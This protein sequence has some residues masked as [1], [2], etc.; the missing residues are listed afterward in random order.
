MTTVAWWSG[1]IKSGSTSS[2]IAAGWDLLPTLCELSGTEVPR[3]LDG[4][5]FAPTLL[6][7]NKDQKKEIIFTGSFTSGEE[8]R[9]FA[10][11]NGKGSDKMFVRTQ[12]LPS[13][14]M[15]CPKILVRKIIL[16]QRTLR[17]LRKSNLR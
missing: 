15:I 5:S 16:L 1:K 12:I 7:R 8:S 2:H 14:S 4:V 17:L 10:W 13:N 9:P 6:G 11:G 3:D